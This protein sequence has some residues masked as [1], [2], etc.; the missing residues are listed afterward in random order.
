MQDDALSILQNIKH[1]ELSEFLL[2]KHAIARI[3]GKELVINMKLPQDGLYA[4]K[5]FA[6]EPK[7]D[8][9][10]LPNV[11]NYL[12]KVAEPGVKNDPYPKLHGGNPGENL[13][14]RSPQCE[15]QR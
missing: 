11:C 3:E 2:Q 15:E 5:L 7:P 10:D 13:P 14:G 9:G 8:A 1:N 4:F 6:D 12:I